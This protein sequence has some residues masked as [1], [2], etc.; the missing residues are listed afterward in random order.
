[1]RDEIAAGLN[2]LG[3]TLKREAEDLSSSPAANKVRTSVD[4]VGEKLRTQEMQ[5]KVRGE[6]INALQMVNSELQ[7]VI[8]R[9]SPAEASTAEPPAAENSQTP[10]NIPAAD[11]S[12]PA[13]DETASTGFEG[14]PHRQA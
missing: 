13:P 6:L 4:Q 5:N 11:F 2:D 3:S 1:M 9:W 12:A 8:D 14:D 7:R 10:E